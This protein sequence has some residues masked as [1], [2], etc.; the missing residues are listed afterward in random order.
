MEKVI[1]AIFTLIKKNEKYLTKKENLP[2]TAKIGYILEV[3][4]KCHRTINPNT[5]VS[6]RNKSE[7]FD[8]DEN[9]RIYDAIAIL[10]LFMDD[11]LVIHDFSTFKNLIL[12]G[13]EI[14]ENEKMEI[15]PKKTIEEWVVMLSNP[16]YRYHSLYQYRLEAIIRIMFDSGTNFKFKNGFIES[17]LSYYNIRPDFGDWKNAKI[18]ED[19]F[20]EIVKLLNRVI[21]K[22]TYD[23]AYEIYEKRK[24]I[25]TERELDN[26]KLMK[27]IED[28]K[29]LLSEKGLEEFYESM[30]SKRMPTIIIFGKLI[31]KLIFHT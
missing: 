28:S 25:K 10:H 4:V 9:S 7:E 3:L 8:L 31:I 6:I 29:K 2:Q 30:N 14:S 20:D 23:K 5:N 21:V 12:E 27:A 22:R 26:D 24:L 1:D 17:P 16:E 15:K 13:I 19:I 11:D 18:R